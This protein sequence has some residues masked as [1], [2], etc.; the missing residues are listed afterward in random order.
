LKISKA[1]QISELFKYPLDTIYVGY[2]KDNK[3]E[4]LDQTRTCLTC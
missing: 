3:I 4:R 2:K 1:I